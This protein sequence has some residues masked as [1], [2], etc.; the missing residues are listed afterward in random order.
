[1]ALDFSAHRGGDVES[2]KARPSIAS[3]CVI[4]CNLHFPLRSLAGLEAFSRGGENGMLRY[5]PIPCRLRKVQSTEAW[6]V[7]DELAENA[8]MMIAIF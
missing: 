2:R 6:P 4:C 8:D 7:K 3:L 1:M 5:V